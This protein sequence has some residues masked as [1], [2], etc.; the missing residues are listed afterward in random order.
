MVYAMSDLHGC[1]D[2]YI[3]M[4]E[5]I[6]FS[7]EDTLYI[8][9]D[10]VDRGPDGIKIYKDMMKR[11]NVIPLLGNHDYTAL[12]MFKMIYNKEGFNYLDLG[13][14]MWMMIGGEPTNN[15]FLELSEREQL[16]I[17]NYISQFTI[18]KDISVDGNK[19]W[20]SHTIPQ[21]DR[22]LHDC[23]LERE[24]FI[25]GA[26]EYDKKYYDNKYIV[27]GHTPTLFISPEY[28]GKIYN[29]NNHIAIDC[30]A[31]FGG[32]LGCICLNDFKEY[33]VE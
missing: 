2:L 28:D 27:T 16:E 18:F 15:A 25:A 24:D 1:Y 12:R 19:F 17:I 13:Y 14:K 32:I 22:M 7:D 23:N 4:L 10:I 26:P 5:K 29:K 21:K 20:L 31:V 3:K 30:G 6:K 33:Y 8:L 11:K 9:G